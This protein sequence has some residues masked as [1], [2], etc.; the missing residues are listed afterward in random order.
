MTFGGAK[1][2][3][4]EEQEDMRDMLLYGGGEGGGD[5]QPK[6]ERESDEGRQQTMRRRCPRR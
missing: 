5:G 6:A 3:G 1:P 2:A 4:R